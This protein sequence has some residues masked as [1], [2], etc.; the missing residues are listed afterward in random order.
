MEISVFWTK[1]CIVFDSQVTV[2]TSSIVWIKKSTHLI[3]KFAN[4]GF[5]FLF[6]RLRP[7]QGTWCI[8]VIDR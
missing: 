8:Q 3:N 1:Q 5:K 2:T 6:H 7:N 4:V